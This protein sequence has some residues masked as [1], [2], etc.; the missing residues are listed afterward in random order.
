MALIKCS[1]CGRDVSD[2][3]S[4][5]PGCGYPLSGLVQ[6]TINDSRPDALDSTGSTMTLGEFAKQANEPII[7]KSGWLTVIGVM[8]TIVAIALIFIRPSAGF[9]CLV[10]GLL[11]TGKQLMAE[12]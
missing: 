10:P 3:A 4:A 2:K 12:D 7:S 11:I 8:L 1:E 5:C 6:G 9:L